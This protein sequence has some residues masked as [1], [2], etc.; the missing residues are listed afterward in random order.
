M[1]YFTCKAQ[2]LTTIETSRV[3]W[4]EC[5]ADY[6]LAKD[7]WKARGTELAHDTWTKAHEYGYQY[8][9]IIED[10]RIVSS[11]GVL[12]FS[13]A[14][15]EVAA[16]GTLEDFRRRGYARSVVAFVTAYILNAGLLAT[17]S[18]SDDNEAMT[19]TAKS[20]GFQVIPKDEVWWKYPNLPDF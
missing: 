9:A 2:D 14:C 16:V 19:A 7:Y 5:A 15:W 13:E 6:A 8:A 18:T 11:A 12:R 20:V 3:R 17:C 4:L 10:G 1:I